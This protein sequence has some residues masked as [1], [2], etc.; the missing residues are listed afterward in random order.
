MG[1]PKRKR[2][3]Y[4]LEYGLEYD[5]NMIGIWENLR[6]YDWYMDSKKNHPRVLHEFEEPPLDPMKNHFSII[7]ICTFFPHEFE[8]ATNT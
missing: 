6:E 4:G 1:K 8:P 2:L 3:V 7:T 5:W